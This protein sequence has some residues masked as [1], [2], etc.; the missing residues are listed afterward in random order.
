MAGKGTTACGPAEPCKHSEALSGFS[1]AWPSSNNHILCLYVYHSYRGA[2]KPVTQ[3]AG[4]ILTPLVSVD[5][6]PLKQECLLDDSRG[7]ESALR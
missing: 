2:F 6:V 5:R 3:M 4:F 1:P 7:H